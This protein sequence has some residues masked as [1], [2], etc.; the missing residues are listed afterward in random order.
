MAK[1]LTAREK[2]EIVKNFT[3]GKT[4]DQLSK[5]F[6]FTKL[7]ISRNLKKHLGEKKYK[8]MINKTKASNKYF[9]NEEKN[10]SQKNKNDLNKKN[11]VNLNILDF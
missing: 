5:E 3:L 8:E 11:I 10:V 1:R 7:T 6:D 2:E 4:V 9:S